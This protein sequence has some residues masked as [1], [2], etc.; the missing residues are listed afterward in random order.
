MTEN[1]NTQIYN[2]KVIQM[3]F[4]QSDRKLCGSENTVWKSNNLKQ[5]CWGNLSVYYNR[6]EL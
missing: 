5:F 3:H 1:Y 4:L 2:S 6:K